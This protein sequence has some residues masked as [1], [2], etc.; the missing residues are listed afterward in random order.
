MAAKIAATM[1]Q[2]HIEAK[3]KRSSKNQ[4]KNGSKANN[5]DVVLVT[6]PFNMTYACL[7]DASPLASHHPS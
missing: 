6:M 7:C 3:R 1:R 4:R 5:D 2:Q